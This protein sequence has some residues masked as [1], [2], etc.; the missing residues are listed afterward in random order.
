M[1]KYI[2]FEQVKTPKLPAVLVSELAKVPDPLQEQIDRFNAM[3]QLSGGI[4]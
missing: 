2:N 3:A 4:V 1:W